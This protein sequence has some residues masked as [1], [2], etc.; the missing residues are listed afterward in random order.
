MY[1][2]ARHST[3]YRKNISC[4]PSIS[5]G[6]PVKIFR[7]AY[8]AIEMYVSPCYNERKGVTRNG[9]SRVPRYAL[10]LH[11]L[12]AEVIAAVFHLNSSQIPH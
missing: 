6:I 12:M 4:I 11:D 7:I 9:L 8:I 1:H 10:S 5:S 2:V 3:L